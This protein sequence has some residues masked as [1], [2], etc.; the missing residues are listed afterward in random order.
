MAERADGMGNNF[1][2]PDEQEYLAGHGP[3]LAARSHVSQA[4]GRLAIE[5]GLSPDAGHSLVDAF[6]TRDIDNLASPLAAAVEVASAIDRLR[7]AMA[8]YGSASIR[9]AQRAA[10]FD[11]EDSADDV[12]PEAVPVA[13]VAT[14]Q[15]SEHIEEPV[16][17]EAIM[18]TL[19]PLKLNKRSLAYVQNI[20]GDVSDL[21]LLEGQQLL[22]AQTINNLRG[23]AT[24]SP[25]HDITLQV[26]L[27]L[28]GLDDATIGQQVNKT[29]GS[30]A[31]SFSAATKKIKAQPGYSPES[32]YGLLAAK[33]ARTQGGEPVVLEVRQ[34]VIEEVDEVIE[35]DDE[36]PVVVEREFKETAQTGR[37]QGAIRLQL[38]KADRDHTVE[39]G[40]VR[41]KELIDQVF[42]GDDVLAEAQTAYME[43]LMT[44]VPQVGNDAQRACIV[45]MPELIVGILTDDRM[46]NVLP[47]TTPTHHHRPPVAFSPASMP[48]KKT[49]LPFVAPQA[50]SSG[51]H[52]VAGSEMTREAADILPL[53]AAA[54][55]ENVMSAE[56]WYKTAHAFITEEV[57]AKLGLSKEEGLGLWDAVHFGKGDAHKLRPP[58]TKVALHALQGVMEEVPEKSWSQ[59]PE[60]QTCLR[61]LLNPFPPSSLGSIQRALQKQDK[62]IGQHAAQRHVVAAISELL[63]DWYG[64]ATA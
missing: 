41:L 17:D 34:P 58:E 31:T 59:Y 38:R 44:G 43:F 39:L 19:Q 64:E 27:L 20:F 21:G 50:Q 61:K 23:K 24:T 28:A 48:Q 5:L 22:I 37:L 30:V 36:V 25:L 62:E 54:Y 16:G 56:V 10:M 15:E 57:P 9:I 26:Q 42:M 53:V 11:V 40:P 32:A 12:L 63:R 52:H 35:A 7:D 2:M 3:G 18:D 46:A 4:A 60:L 1:L 13:S 49:V 47:I 8:K 14:I 51:H 45:A 33:L 29:R 55:S 6:R